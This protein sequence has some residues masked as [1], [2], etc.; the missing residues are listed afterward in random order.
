[1]NFRERVY[2]C[3]YR[4]FEESIVE[5][6]V[7]INIST[8]EVKMRFIKRGILLINETWKEIIEII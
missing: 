7:E 5:I 1:M 8:Q 6:N 2:I 4:K 3:I